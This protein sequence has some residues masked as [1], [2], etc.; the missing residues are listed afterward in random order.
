MLD[1]FVVFAFIWAYSLRAQYYNLGWLSAQNYIMGNPEIK[2]SFNIYKNITEADSPASLLSMLS[3]K[4]NPLPNN[5]IVAKT[6]G[7]KEQDENS[8]YQNYLHYFEVNKYME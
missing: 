5:D 1:N 3:D 4:V 8:I 6:D 2:N 7:I